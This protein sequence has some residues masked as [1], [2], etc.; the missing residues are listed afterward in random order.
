MTEMSVN[1]KLVVILKY[2][3]AMQE[4][5][6]DDDFDGLK[7]YVN[8]FGRSDIEHILMEMNE[9]S[10]SEN[11][12]DVDI[13]DSIRSIMY[14]YEDMEV[15]NTRWE[16]MLSDI[17]EIFHDN[18]DNETYQE[19][20]DEF[21]T[22]MLEREYEYRNFITYLVFRYFAKSVYDY[23]VVGKAKMFITNYI[24]LRQICLCGIKRIRGSHLMTE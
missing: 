9:E 2:C 13:Q 22:A 19:T 4:Y 12:E 21:M 23:D 7:E 20:E 16:D 24:I 8:T 1:E 17:V 5:I 14:S 15:L 6:N 3:A 11:F 18:M 10:D